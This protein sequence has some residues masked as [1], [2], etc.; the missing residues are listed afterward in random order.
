MAEIGLVR[1]DDV[2]LAGTELRVLEWLPAH[3]GI[4]NVRIDRLPLRP[5]LRVKG[6]IDA[7]VEVVLLADAFLEG[8]PFVVFS[9]EDVRIGLRPI[10]GSW[11]K[12]RQQ[13]KSR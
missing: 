6:I 9:I 12:L 5:P 1:G 4:V 3:I 13:P 11:D 7:E 2:E 8:E 10:L